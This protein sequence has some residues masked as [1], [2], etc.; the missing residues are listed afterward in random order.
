[1]NIQIKIFNY[2]ETGMKPLD[3]ATIQSLTR[4]T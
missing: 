4:T 3:A 2:R 1:M